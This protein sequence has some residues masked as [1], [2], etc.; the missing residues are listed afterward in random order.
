MLALYVA[1][2]SIYKYLFSYVNIFSNVRV[3]VGCVVGKSCAVVIVLRLLLVLVT[4]LVVSSESFQLQGLGGSLLGFLRHPPP[5]CLFLSVSPV[6]SLVVFKMGYIACNAVIG[7]HVLCTYH[8][9]F[10]VCY[11][12]GVWIKWW[13]EFVYFLLFYK[14][15]VSDF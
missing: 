4:V 8:C 3:G 12:I 13:C 1:K 5:Q 9:T 11:T 15:F 2:L 14:Y 6:L 10:Y 7:I